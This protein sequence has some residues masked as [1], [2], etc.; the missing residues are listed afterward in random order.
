LFQKRNTGS[1]C[2]KPSRWALS[3]AF[4][5]AYW[6]TAINLDDESLLET[7]EVNDIGAD[8]LLTPELDASR[9]A[10]SQDCPKCAFCIRL[11]APKLACRRDQ[12]LLLLCHLAFFSP[13]P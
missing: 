7:D 12:L 9:L 10:A 2:F 13:S 8:G 1:L 6:L 3:A 5:C 4:T 11:L